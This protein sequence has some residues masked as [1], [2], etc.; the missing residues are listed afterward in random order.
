MALSA[1]GGG[2]SD[3][4]GQGSSGGSGGR[5]VYGESTDWPENLMPLISAGNALSVANIEAQLL[6]Q[7]YLIQPDLTV[8]YDDQFMAD[9]PTS[10]VNGDSQTVTYHI[11]PDAVWSDGQPITA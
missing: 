5:V 8:K 2:S 10:Q 6:P 7:V 1:C 4:S 9:E 11:N 3:N